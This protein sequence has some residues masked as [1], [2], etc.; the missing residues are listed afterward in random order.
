MT[1]DEKHFDVIDSTRDGINRLQMTASE[2]LAE[3]RRQPPDVTSLINARALEA[4]SGI[5]NLTDVV[6]QSKRQ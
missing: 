4:A 2:L 5:D 1:N 6:D 3:M